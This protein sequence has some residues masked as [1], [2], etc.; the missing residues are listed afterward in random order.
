MKGNFNITFSLFGDFLITSKYLCDIT[1]LIF[2]VE[3]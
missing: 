1:F 3:G 2:E